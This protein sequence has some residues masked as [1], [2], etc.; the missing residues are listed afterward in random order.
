MLWLHGNF[1]F[2][3]VVGRIKQRKHMYKL[4]EKGYEVCSWVWIKFCVVWPL[5]WFAKCILKMEGL[6]VC[7]HLNC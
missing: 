2:G 6:K 4:V 7:S 5:F 3:C 1:M